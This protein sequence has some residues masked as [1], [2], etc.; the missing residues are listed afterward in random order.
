VN[1]ALQDVGLIASRS[2]RRTVRQPA[3]VIA[4]LTFPILLLAINSSGLRAATHIPG[5]P[6]NSFVVLSHPLRSSRAHSSPR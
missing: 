6:T 2:V 4:P 1:L 5:F 3:N